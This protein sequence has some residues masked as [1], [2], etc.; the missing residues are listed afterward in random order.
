MPTIF[1]KNEFT[2][3]VDGLTKLGLTK[4]ESAVYLSLLQQG[5][6]RSSKIISDTGLHSQFVYQALA[7]LEEKG[8]AQHTIM[9]GRKKFSAKAPTVLQALVEQKKKI[10]DNIQEK[11]KHMVIPPGLHQFE[12]FQGNDSFISNEFDLLEKAQE[13]ASLLVIGG[14][15]DA[16]AKTLGTQLNEYEYI[17]IKKNIRVRYIGSEGQRINLTN[18]SE[19]RKLFEFRLLPGLFT[20]EVNTNILPDSVGFNIFGEPTTNFT[21]SNTMIAESYRQ[22]FETLWKLA[23]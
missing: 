3:I 16:F 10:A 15:G 17:R 2:D 9:R 7:G 8:L 1:D 23:R 6:V 11:L 22:F 14:T 20:G 19:T 5:E 21:V 4:K 12:I 13:G 18:D